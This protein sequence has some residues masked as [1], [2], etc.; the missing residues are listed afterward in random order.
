M[1]DSAPTVCAQALVTVA[2]LSAGSRLRLSP[3]VR[4]DARLARRMAPITLLF[5]AML[6]TSSRALRRCSVPVVTI[7]KNLAVVA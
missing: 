6:W 4:L 1:E 3:R 2:L 5:V 7:F